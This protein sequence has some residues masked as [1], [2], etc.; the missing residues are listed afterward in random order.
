MYEIRQEAATTAQ[1]LDV[2][3]E[4]SAVLQRSVEKLETSCR[5]AS[6]AAEEAGAS[7]VEQG[8]SLRAEIATCEG[9]ITALEAA[10]MAL[11]RRVDEKIGSVSRTQLIRLR[12]EILLHSCS[13]HLH[14]T[15]RNFFKILCAP[16]LVAHYEHEIQRLDS[17][18]TATT[19]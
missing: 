11:G 7:V 15:F 16:I 8:R 4:E 10:I 17:C 12:L 6:A 18:R 5:R 19:G 2:A 3:V 13:T 14:Y 9:R 1:R